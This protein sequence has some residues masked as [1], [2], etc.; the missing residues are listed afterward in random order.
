MY[1]KFTGKQYEAYKQLTEDYRIQDHALQV[2][3]RFHGTLDWES[4]P[5]APLNEIERYALVQAVVNNH[6]EV[7]LSFQENLEALLEK[8]A[9]EYDDCEK[10][11][12]SD[13][14][15][16]GPF[17][18]DIQEVS[19]HRKEIVWS[20]LQLLNKIYRMYLAE[21]GAPYLDDG[22]GDDEEYYPYDGEEDKKTE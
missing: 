20:N 18:K 8:Y 7:R 17:A 19:E 10:Q 6:F 4:G 9:K 12:Q 21:I 13:N 16:Q 15:L 2:I 22:D 11:I 1:A 14:T 3:Y 5:Y